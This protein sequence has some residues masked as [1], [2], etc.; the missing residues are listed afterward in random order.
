MKSLFQDVLYG[1]RMLAK[2]PGFT[3][4]VVL[5]LALG[6]GA[7]SAIFSVANELLL[8]PL[9]SAPSDRFVT[10]TETTGP[11]GAYYRLVSPPNFVDWQAQNDVFETMAAYQGQG[12]L[13]TE[14]EEPDR[15]WG[16]R[17]TPEF[18]RLVGAHPVLGRSFLPAEQRPGNENVVILGDGLWER[19]FGSDPDIL[20]KSVKLSGNFYTVVGVMP[21]GFTLPMGWAFDVYVPLALTAEE[22]SDGNRASRY[23]LVWAFLK[24]GVSIE[25]ARAEMNTIAKRLEQQYPETN[26]EWGVKIVRPREQMI[27]NMGPVFALLFFGVGIVLLIACGNAAHLFLVRAATRQ[28]EIAIR[29]ALGAQRARLI[30]QFL[31][32]SVMIAL[33]GG[34]FGLL[35]ALW[36]TKGIVALIPW[37]DELP[38]DATVLTF[39]VILSC[40]TGVL[41]GSAAAFWLSR[42]NLSET[43]KEG[44]TRASMGAGRKRIRQIMVVSQIALSTILLVGASLMIKSFVEIQRTNLGFDTEN[45]LTM[46]LFFHEGSYATPTPRRSLYRAILEQVSALP[47]VRSVAVSNGFPMMMQDTRYFEIVGKDHSGEG[48]R[49]AA[50]YRA[51]SS[52][53]FR[54]LGISVIRGRLF[55]ESDIEG[56][57]AVVLINETLARRYFPNEEPV[58]QFLSVAEPVGGLHEAAPRD[59]RQIVGVVE[60]AKYYGPFEPA[61]PLFYV[62]YRQHPLPRLQVA[63]RTHSDPLSLTRAVREV[64]RTVDKDIGVSN[65][66]SMDQRVSNY[67]WRRRFITYLVSAVAALALLLAAMG[68]YALMAY[69][70]AQRNHEIGIR[71]AVGAQLRDVVR[72]VVGQGLRLALSGLIV[73]VVGAIA[74]LRLLQSQMPAQQFRRFIG[75]DSIDATT[76]LGALMTILAV[77]LLATYIPAR[78]AAKIDPMVALR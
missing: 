30:R 36:G 6:L 68:T 49:P 23:L 11:T 57:A 2:S 18:F 35:F 43:L 8:E 42:V 67:L 25:Q 9:R 7:N 39:T 29:A 73:G 10:L 20:G 16:A 19:Q 28:K 40:V 75:V 58:G 13:L 74:L 31:T 17:I 62:P 4:V 59:P 27:E 32:E 22:L 64:F 33:F 5:L 26:R 63:V 65:I 71:I 60:D 41:F 46:R 77:A 69:S 70:V 1:L 21:K 15:A 54:T 44:S 34:A 51:I 56:A 50:Q 52:G 37:L 72:M 61:Q 24:P 12:F 38:M 3:T 53:Y 48:N 45:L 66:W 14:G 76:L 55:N 47:D 78:R